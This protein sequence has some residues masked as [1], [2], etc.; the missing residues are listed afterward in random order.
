MVWKV[1]RVVTGHDRNGKS[2]FLSDGL[3]PNVKEMASMPGLALTDLWE[4]AAPASNLGDEDAVARPVQL[5]P[6]NGGTILRIVEFPPDS[7]GAIVP[8]RVPLR[9]NRRWAREGLRSLLIR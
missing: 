6:P 8:T 7:H 9:F 3:A 1:R 4:T 2:K 5:E